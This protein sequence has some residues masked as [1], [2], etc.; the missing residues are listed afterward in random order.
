MGFTQVKEWYK[1]LKDGCTLVDNE[2][3]SGRPSTSTVVMR[4]CHM[5]IREIAGEVDITTFLAHS[6]VTKDIAM[7]RVVAKFVP[8]LL[9]TE[10]TFLAQN[11][12]LVVCQAPYSSDKALCVFWL[13]PN[14]RGH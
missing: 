14:L 1:K 3:H 4:D 12:A 13:F 5:T 11:Q 8:K 9:M 2:P 6:I 10:Q 7:K